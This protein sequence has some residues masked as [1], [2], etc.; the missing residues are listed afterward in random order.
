MRMVRMTSA[1]RTLHLRR[2]A[3]IDCA[4]TLATPLMF[5][6]VRPT[7]TALALAHHRTP[8]PNP[9]GRPPWTTPEQFEYLQ[10]HLPNLDNEKANNGLTQHYAR[11]ARDFSVIWKPPIVEKDRENAKDED[12]LKRLA[13]ERRACVSQCFSSSTDRH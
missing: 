11:I 4:W 13:Y 12:E 3:D 5:G 10:K 8:M 1:A 6:W 9:V 2:M 7:S